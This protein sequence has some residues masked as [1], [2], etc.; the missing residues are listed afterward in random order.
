MMPLRLPAG[1]TFMNRFP[2][3][4]RAQ[5]LALKYLVCVTCLVFTLFSFMIPLF[6]K[7]ECKQKSHRE[8]KS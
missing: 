2:F 7:R 3:E 1:L 4:T 8:N 6:G 5:S